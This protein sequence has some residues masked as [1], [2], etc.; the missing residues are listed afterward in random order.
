MLGSGFQLADEFDHI[1]LGIFL[2][3]N[4]GC[5]KEGSQEQD[6]L[7]LSQLGIRVFLKADIRHQQGKP[8]A[9]I[10]FQCEMGGVL[11]TENA[12]QPCNTQDRQENSFE[13]QDRP[14]PAGVAFSRQISVL[15]EV[16]PWGRAKAV[17]VAKLQDNGLKNTSLVKAKEKQS[18]D[19]RNC[20]PHKVAGTSQLVVLDFVV[21][22]FGQALQPFRCRFSTKC[23]VGFPM[24]VFFYRIGFT[25][26]LFCFPEPPNS[27]LLVGS[28]ENFHLPFKCP[29]LRKTEFFNDFRNFNN[30][31]LNKCSNNF[32]G[33]GCGFAPCH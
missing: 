10:I 21:P 31:V 27:F 23:S 19:Q 12:Q 1:R 15:P 17:I 26:S 14:E 33:V 22:V 24:R 30:N 6:T 20:K 3:R 11:P 28:G 2:G 4:F 16:L 18:C 25:C 5:S 8:L 29:A 32:I 7:F 9:S 13:A